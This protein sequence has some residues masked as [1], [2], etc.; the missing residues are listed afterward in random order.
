MLKMVNYPS[1]TESFIKWGIPVYLKYVLGVME[2]LLAVGIFYKP[3][4]KYAVFTGLVVM[5][6]AIYVH[7]SNNEAGQL[8]G[9]GFVVALLIAL[10]ISND[11]V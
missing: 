10:L 2:I 1:I 6:G 5:A 8:Y 4:R 9:P 7:I 11:L 3:T